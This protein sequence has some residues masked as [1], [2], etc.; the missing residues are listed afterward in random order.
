[1]LSRCYDSK[2]IGFDNYGGRGIKVC[3]EWRDFNTFLH[4]MGSAPQGMTIDRIDVNG[5]YNKQNCRW[6]S[7]KQQANNK[8]NNYLLTAF[9]ETKTIT[10]WANEYNISLYTIK[11]RIE[12]LSWPIEKAISQKARA[13][14]KLSA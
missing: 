5:D 1:M 4:D 2:N 13:K 7:Y 6:A 12:D 11:K 14:R 10:Q 3:T 9:G 8:R